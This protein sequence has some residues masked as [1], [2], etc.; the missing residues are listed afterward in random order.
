MLKRI[1]K[2]VPIFLAC[3][4]LVFM[5]CQKNE[6]TSETA[7][8]STDSL[9]TAQLAD[10]ANCGSCHQK[11]Y[12]DWE[13]SHHALALRV[14]QDSLFVK[15]PDTVRLSEKRWYALYKKDGKYRINTQ[16]Y[17]DK[18]GDFE[19]K[20][21]IG[22]DPLLQYIAEIP[23]GKNQCLTF[24]FDTRKKEYFDLKYDTKAPA[25]DWLHW[26]GQSM[27][28]NSA[29]ADCH[30]TQVKKG[31]DPLTDSYKTTYRH[32][33]ITCEG[34]HGTVKELPEDKTACWLPAE[35]RKEIKTQ[36]SQVENCAT[37][38]AR[39]MQLQE[40]KPEKA[41]F[42]DVYTLEAP[43][44]TTFHADGQ[45][46]DEVFEYHSFTQS[47]MFAKGVK[48]ANCHNTHSGKLL[49]TG[50]ALCTN[51]HEKKRF[52]TPT[53]HFHSIE[54]T[55]AQCVNCHMPGKFY[56]GRHFR[57]DHSLRIPRPDLT[58]KFN[59]PNACNNCHKDKKATWA[60]KAVEK[61]HGKNRKPHFSD[62]ILNAS[63]TD[64]KSIE[65]ILA[66]IKNDT[67]R[68]TP[69]LLVL[70]KYNEL[71]TDEE[72]LRDLSELSK[73][74]S[75]V[76]RNHYLS[77]FNDKRII[78]DQLNATLVDPSRSVRIQ[79]AR[80]YNMLNP[81]APS[82]T[83]T[84]EYLTMTRFNEDNHTIILDVA[85]Y[86]FQKNN[87]NEAIRLYK[88]GITKDDKQPDLYINLVQAYNSTNQ[89]D[90]ALRILEKGTQKL[91]D[92][93]EFY[94]YKGLL[95]MEKGQIEIAIANLAKASKLD[96][97]NAQYAY[98]LS[99]IFMQQNKWKEAETYL[100]KAL[101]AE[102]ANQ[103]YKD[104]WVYLKQKR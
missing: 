100:K 64:T 88:K 18:K 36:K 67:N 60:A 94:F 72:K 30:S 57:H 103:K 68:V 78:N 44:A 101:Q 35:E 93:A 56:M 27:N 91:P 16:D 15:L 65:A 51:C 83:A 40:D 84:S 28:W 7:T 77:L 76:I 34:C 54:S 97:S 45:I 63:K 19:I 9:L 59:T 73:D 81:T 74:P 82:N 98:N 87:P 89:K 20:Y 24:A 32:I 58:V 104:A 31:Y 26:T 2:L 50:N 10:P 4:W 79:A 13:N 8:T 39:R 1:A 95:L 92:Y 41:P 21:V 17:F 75:S 23:N 12:K 42:D 55:G 33:Q 99:V 38:H 53:H 62:L 90:S 96:P 14:P 25:G 85:N 5:A 22:V 69:R 52:D 47:K 29:C 66:Y 48:C 3:I 61:W 49:A 46:K 70:N 43:S 71:S 86:Y 37:C 102:P 11:Q 80:Y 6:E